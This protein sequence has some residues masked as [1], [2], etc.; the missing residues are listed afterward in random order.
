MSSTADNIRRQLE[1][2]KDTK[3]SEEELLDSIN[4]ASNLLIKKFLANV[5]AGSIEMT[6][7]TDLVRIISMA[8]D[9]NNW[10]TGTGATGAPPA[11][12]LKQADILDRTLNTK[13]EMVDGEEVDVV[14]LSELE[15]MSNEDLEAM[16]R[17]REI[18]YNQENE[19]TF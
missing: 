1:R 11:I 6:E 8:S 16:L 18:S 12:S 9:V 15:A 2:K 19:A 10:S 4:D 3:S 5:Q 7:V 13:K 17:E 14:D